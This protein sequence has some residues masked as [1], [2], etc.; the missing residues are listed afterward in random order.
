MGL[1]EM[2]EKLFHLEG[3]LLYSEVL[4]HIWF[5]RVKSPQTSQLFAENL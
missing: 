5:P 2:P 3:A 1:L 4:F